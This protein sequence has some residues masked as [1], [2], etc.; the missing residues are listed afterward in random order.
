M[1]EHECERVCVCVCVCSLLGK[2]GVLRSDR[3]SPKIKT[4]LEYGSVVRAL[5]YCKKVQCLKSSNDRRK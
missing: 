3:F 5:V 2:L 4:G 1:C